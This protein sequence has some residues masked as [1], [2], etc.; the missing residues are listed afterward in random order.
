MQFFIENKEYI[1]YLAYAL[2]LVFTYLSKYYQSNSKL[3]TLVQ[4]VVNDVEKSFKSSALSGEEKS[5]KK[6]EYATA[7]L[8]NKIPVMFKPFL[9][10]EKLQNLI[11]DCVNSMNAFAQEQLD[12]AVGGLPDPKPRE[13]DNARDY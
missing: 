12:Y 13:G 8:Y 6:L 9:T 2:L 7:M 4:D 11:S 3:K 10:K 5:Y 1:D